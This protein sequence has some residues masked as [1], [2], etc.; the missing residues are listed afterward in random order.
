LNTGDELLLVPLGGVGEIGMNLALYGFGPPQNHDWIMVDCG[1]SFAGNDL[2]GIDLVFPDIRFAEELG[3]RLKA[4]VIT[5][6][7]EDHYGALI[8]LWPRFG[9]PV[10]MTAFT[11]GLLTAKSRS[12]PGE[13]EIPVRLFRAGDRFEIGPFG[14]EAVHVAHSIPEPVALAL[15]TPLGCVLH[16]GDWKIDAAPSLGPNTDGAAL[17]RLGAE[18]VFAMICDSTNAT[19]PGT[20][21]TESEV[22]ASL[23]AIIAEAT[24]RVA[25]TT[26][27]SNVGRIRSIALA[28]QR[29]GRRTMLMGRSIQRMVDVAGE[30]GMM[31]DIEDFVPE[32]EYES[33]P[34]NEL[35]IILTGSQGENRAALAKLARQEHPRIR[36]GSGDIVIYSSRTIPGNEKAINETKNLLID[37][38]IELIGDGDR[39]VHVSGHPRQDELKQMY[40]WV[41]PGL[42]VPVH[43]EAAHLDAHAHFALAS[44]IPEVVQIRNGDVLRLAPGQAEI[45]GRAPS[46]RIF[47]D[48]YIVGDAQETGLA[49]RRKLSFSGLVACSVVL[50]RHGRLADDVDIEL[51][52]LP[53]RTESEEPFD[54]IL[55]DAAIGALQSI[56]KGRRKD[57]DT[58]RE[59]ISKAIRAQCRDRWGK[60][61]TVTV[62][63]ARV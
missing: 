6:A 29:A 63:V 13:M 27:S 46:G 33:T 45:I 10:W 50:D 60:K 39:L 31:D 18:G 4:I 43:G 49:V 7:H 44:G 54:D 53:S 2:P 17:Q 20:S 30:L 48:G 36:L 9:C 61:P 37:Q 55:F 24:G 19:R 52:G 12:Q 47:K 8:D 22:A 25:V 57:D 14:I 11:A 58:I 41:K 38:G 34:R 3:D 59:A 40:D 62:F 1:V 28:A 26:F 23:E 21:P 16:T 35:V 5:H 42:L 32:E 51:H 56:P 15:R